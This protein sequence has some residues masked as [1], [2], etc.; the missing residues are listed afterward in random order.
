MSNLL[1]RAKQ[2]TQG[3][4]IL[5]AWLGSGAQTV[6][7]ELAQKRANVCI[8]CPMNIKESKLS[9][10]VAEAIKSQL[11]IKSKLN[12]R[13]DGEKSLLGC[14]VCGCETRLKIWVPLERILP[15]ADEMPLFHE[16]CW[17]RSESK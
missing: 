12:L 2:F 10:A 1:D 15:D 14:A 4:A 8:E 3:T 16:S 6:S 13:V 7:Q 5:T 17:L 11:E 9:S